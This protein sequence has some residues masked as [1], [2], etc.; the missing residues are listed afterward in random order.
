[1][2]L[3]VEAA[4]DAIAHPRPEP[5]AAVPV[6]CQGVLQAFGR[7]GGL[8]VRDESGKDVTEVV[9]A[10]G[11]A[12]LS[13]PTRGKRMQS[14]SSTAL[15]RSTRSTFEPPRDPNALTPPRRSDRMQVEPTSSA[16]VPRQLSENQE[17]SG[18]D[19]GMHRDGDAVFGWLG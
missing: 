19:H 11:G 12:G 13:S 8:R 14:A 5:Y 16:S 15:V 4:V 17:T 7:R 3:E 6:L 2:R 10:S 18:T 9:R 1:M